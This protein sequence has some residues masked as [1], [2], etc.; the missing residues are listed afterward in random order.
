MDEVTYDG[1]RCST[2][3]D[4]SDARFLRA[5]LFASRN[6]RHR[7]VNFLI[8]NEQE[9]SIEHLERLLLDYARTRPE[10]GDAVDLMASAV[11]ALLR[12]TGAYRRLFPSIE[13][14]D[15]WQGSLS[16]SAGE[17]IDAA[18][19][20]AELDQIEDESEKP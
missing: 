19:L 5:R 15:A 20:A 13:D 18:Q 4:S 12:P 11:L 16:A 17:R 8:D 9:P 1:E 3:K 6:R 7:I 14:A 2:T 10:P